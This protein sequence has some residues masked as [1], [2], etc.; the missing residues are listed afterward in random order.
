M[1]ES[2][3]VVEGVAVMMKVA[4]HA[5]NVREMTRCEKYTLVVVVVAVN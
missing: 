5:I 3:G 1:E 4:M 2:S